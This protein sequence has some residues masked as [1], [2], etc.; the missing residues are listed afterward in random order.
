[1]ALANRDDLG[2]IQRGVSETVHDHRVTLRPQLTDG[3][4]GLSEPLGAAAAGAAIP[5][6]AAA[7]PP[8]T[9][10]AYPI[11]FTTLPSFLLSELLR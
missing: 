7:N 1:M 2:P 5:M 8:T 11:L 6:I 9:A 10:V 4:Y 3:L